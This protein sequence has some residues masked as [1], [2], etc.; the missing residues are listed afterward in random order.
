MP[1]KTKLK[2]AAMTTIIPAHAP[3]HHAQVQG[4]ELPPQR[5]RGAQGSQP[6]AVIVRPSFLKEFWVA[7]GGGI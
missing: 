6:R 1:S 4:Q 5:D 2:N 7:T 3:L